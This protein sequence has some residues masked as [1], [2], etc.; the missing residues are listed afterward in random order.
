MPVSLGVYRPTFL[1]QQQDHQLV[2][3][4]TITSHNLS[5]TVSATYEPRLIDTWQID[6]TGIHQDK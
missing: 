6:N 5:T 3:A 1:S 4:D 2:D